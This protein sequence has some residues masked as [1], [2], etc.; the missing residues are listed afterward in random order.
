MNELEGV[1]GTE[2]F[3]SQPPAV[4]V[5]WLYGA[6]TRMLEVLGIFFDGYILVE[7][8]GAN[9]LYLVLRRTVETLA[10]DF[11]EVEDALRDFT[12]LFPNLYEAV[13]HPDSPD[14]N[15]EIHGPPVMGLLKAR[16]SEAVLDAG[17]APPTEVREAIQAAFGEIDKDIVAFREAHTQKNAAWLRRV[18]QAAERAKPLLESAHSES[19]LTES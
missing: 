11:P 4:K 2:S 7:D 8:E 19:A 14:E 12:D 15:W 9:R 16:L 18:K 1:F 10:T 17:T 3:G 5:E 13:G 6:V